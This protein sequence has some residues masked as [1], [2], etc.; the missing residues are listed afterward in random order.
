MWL[1]KKIVTAKRSLLL[2]LLLP[3]FG[4]LTCGRMGRNFSVATYTHCRRYTQ[5]IWMLCLFIAW[6]TTDIEPF[7]L[8]YFIG[9]TPG[10]LYLTWTLWNPQLSSQLYTQCCRCW[11]VYLIMMLTILLHLFHDNVCFNSHAGLC[12]A[13]PQQHAPLKLTYPIKYTRRWPGAGL[14]LAQRLRRW[15]SIRPAPSQRLVFGTD[16]SS[17]RSSPDDF[18]IC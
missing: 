10:D 16:D 3:F 18:I 13:T 11:F 5:S 17:K 6:P 4:I 7:R 12:T 9:P 1:D 14:M 8:C 2:L 15:A